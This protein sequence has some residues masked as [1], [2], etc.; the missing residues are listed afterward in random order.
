MG[1]FP[2]RQRI[3]MT[4]LPLEQRFVPAKRVAV[5]GT[6]WWC[7]MDK[8]RKAFSTFTCHGKYRTKK[9]CIAAI[10][11]WNGRYGDEGFK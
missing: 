5:D 2:P 8:E 7:V 6:G 11:F 1:E 9:E 4:H 3:Y 10:A